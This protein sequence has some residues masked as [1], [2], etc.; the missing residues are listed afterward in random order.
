[1]ICSDCNIREVINP[2]HDGGLC[3]Q[4][5]A[6]RVRKRNLRD[7]EANEDDTNAIVPAVVATLYGDNVPVDSRPTPGYEAG[8]GDTGGAGATE[9]WGPGNG[10]GDTGGSD[11]GA[12]GSDA[13]GGGSDGGGS[14]D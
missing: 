4:C 6:E 11:A 9:N 12:G 8:G 2:A 7:E 13:G 5:H 10:S 3:P 14:S 1:M